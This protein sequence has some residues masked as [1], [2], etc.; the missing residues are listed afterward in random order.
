MNQIPMENSSEV[1]G[2]KGSR[3]RRIFRLQQP[4]D[5]LFAWQYNLDYLRYA[6]EQNK[7]SRGISGHLETN[8]P[9]IF[10]W[11]RQSP[12]YPTRAYLEDD[13]LYRF[14]RDV[15]EPGMVAAVF[16]SEGRLLDSDACCEFGRDQFIV[17]GLK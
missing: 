5:R 7:P 12:R 14:N 10:F 2:A 6:R 13:E 16:N 8:P 17:S 11:D 4:A 15:L 1:L 9:A 3:A